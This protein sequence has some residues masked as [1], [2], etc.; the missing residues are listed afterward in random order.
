MVRALYA[1]GRVTTKA[2]GRVAHVLWLEVTGFFFLFLAVVGG[3][4]AV[5]EYHRMAAHSA[6]P[7]K[8]YLA[9]GFAVMFAY[10]GVSSFLKARRK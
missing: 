8:M 1:A 3:A 5:R 4:A 6:T 9:I 7:S 2:V 10:F